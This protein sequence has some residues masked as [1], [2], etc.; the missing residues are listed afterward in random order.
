MRT[1]G[2]TVVGPS[3]LSDKIVCQDAHFQTIIE[4]DIAIIAVADGL[5]SVAHSD[6]GAQRSTEFAVNYIQ[7]HIDEIKNLSSHDEDSYTSFFTELIEKTRTHLTDSS[8][9]NGYA[10]AE[11][12]C[13][14]IIVI[15]NGNS[16][17]VLH[18]G[19]GAVVIRKEDKFELLSEPEP[20]EYAN[21]VYPITLDGWKN[22]M[23]IAFSEG[24]SA[25]AVF[26]D[27]CQ[28]AL[29]SKAN[30]IWSPYDS[31]FLTLFSWADEQLDGA[32]AKSEIES[33]LN[34]RLAEWNDDKTLVVTVMPPT[35]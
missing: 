14:L 20:S 5:G 1:Y 19:D 30:N 6:I 3:H 33:F 26:T 7:E 12:A 2:A 29:L 22:H 10:L 27:G 25:V 11:M 4:P 16:I 23:R 32:K 35:Q 24:I 21:E 8:Q 34:T 18:I 31:A 28:G 15:I 9:S 13:T 17:S